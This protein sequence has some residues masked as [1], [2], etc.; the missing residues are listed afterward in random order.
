[1]HSIT[2]ARRQ[3]PGFSRSVKLC[4]CR[5]IFIVGGS[6]CSRQ[7]VGVDITYRYLASC[8]TRTHTLAILTKPCYH[9]DHEQV[10][11]LSGWHPCPT[12]R[13]CTRATSRAIQVDQGTVALRG[14]SLWDAPALLAG[15]G[16]AWCGPARAAGHSE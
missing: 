3:S 14:A 10:G 4:S 13:G 15:A 7:G 5:D 8:R 16:G 12:G 6:S 9:I 1:M 11:L 2:P